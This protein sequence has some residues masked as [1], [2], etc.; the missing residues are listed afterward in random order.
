MRKFVILLA[1]LC[2]A[3]TTHHGNFTLVSNKIVNVKDFDLTNSPKQKN[4]VGEDRK[5]IIFFYSTGTP[6]VAAA[7]N[8]VFRNTDTDLLTNA[9]IEYSYWYIPLIYGQRA[10]VVTGD[11]V[12]TRDN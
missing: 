10:W 7:L 2:G 3:C 4:A 11:A 8:D 6:T 5:H 9:S 1:L 12:K